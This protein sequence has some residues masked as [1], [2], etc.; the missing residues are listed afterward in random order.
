MR[1]IP[2]VTLAAVDRFLVDIQPHEHATVRRDR[3]SVCG[4]GRASSTSHAPRHN[5][6]QVGSP[7]VGAPL[8]RVLCPWE[9]R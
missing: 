7:G 3:L 4:S 1:P 9:G 6:E 5:E 2:R 8:A